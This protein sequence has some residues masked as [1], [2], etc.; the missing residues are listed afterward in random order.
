MYKVE[1]TAISKCSKSVYINPKTIFYN[2]NGQQKS[3]DFV[4]NID[5]VAVLVFH[6]QKNCFIFVKQFRPPVFEHLEKNLNIFDTEKTPKGFTI[7]LVAGL[8]DKKGLSPEEAVREEMIEEIGYRVDTKRIEK[9][10][11]YLGNVGISGF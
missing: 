8:L 1:K 7:E 3:W 4:E 2:Q 5:S 11:A 6:K 10:V 9:I